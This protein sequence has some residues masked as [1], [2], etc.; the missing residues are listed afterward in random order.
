[1]RLLLLLLLLWASFVS[2]DR[3]CVILLLV[4]RC[5][6]MTS[7]CD[8]EA[9]NEWFGDPCVG[10]PKYLSVVHE[11]RHR[12]SG[13]LLVSQCQSAPLFASPPTVRSCR[14]WSAGSLWGRCAQRNARCSVTRRCRRRRRYRVM[15]RHPKRLSCVLRRCAPLR[16][17]DVVPCKRPLQLAHIRLDR[18]AYVHVI[19]AR[20]MS[21]VRRDRVGLSLARL[22]CDYLSV[23]INSAFR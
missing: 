1:M 9:K 17:R 6:G 12:N 7:E 23:E 21:D 15:R 13:T 3:R 18:R 5:D 8:I 20:C 11:C 22:A 2:A 10:T 16:I 4:R 14:S 19:A